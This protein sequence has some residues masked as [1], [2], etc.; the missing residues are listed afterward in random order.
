[1]LS[2][3]GLILALTL[4]S[5]QTPVTPPP[6]P[7]D[8]QQR[9]AALPADVQV[10]ERFR[11][12]AGFQPPEVQKEA[13][14]HYDDYLR[15]L[16]VAPGDRAKQL[17]T[18]ESGGRRLEVDRWNRILTSEKPTFNTQPNAF[19]MEM[20]KGRAPG[21]ALDV[22]MGQGRN[23]LYLAQ[24]GWAVTGF[25]PADKAV[26]QANATA[27]K[28]GVKLTTVVQGSEDFDF[29]ENR[30]DL[31]VLSYVTVRDIADR[32]VRSLKPGGIVV[33]EAFHRDVTRER[34]V[35]GGVVFD[36]NELLN[37]FAKLRVLRYEDA[38]ATS[39]FGGAGSR[40]VRLCAVKEKPRQ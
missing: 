27:A 12:W 7:A 18:I 13:V 37:L 17:K 8:L 24:Q 15:A 31:V 9:L 28:L 16:G 25:D 10:Y 34:P 5:G 26:A 40:A 4:S 33:V 3:A 21:A 22:G 35:G 6:L 1:M 38:D 30:W 11:Y 36:S 23:A 20:V 19:L 2:T 39:D 14:R 29:G 32:V